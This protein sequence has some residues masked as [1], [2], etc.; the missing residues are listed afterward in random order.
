M[1]SKI[2]N[3]EITYSCRMITNDYKTI[4]IDGNP[5]IKDSRRSCEVIFLHL[6]FKLAVIQVRIEALLFQQ[7]FMVALLDN[8]SAVH[9]ENCVRF[10]DGRKSV[11]D[12]EAVLPSI[13][14]AKAF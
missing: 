14:F 10:L 7:F 4:K 5:I 11:R 2:N 13:I 8:V 9:D 3:R 12:N 1:I 6:M